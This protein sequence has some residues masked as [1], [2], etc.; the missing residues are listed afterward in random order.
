MTIRLQLVT[1]AEGVKKRTTLSVTSSYAT[2]AEALEAL[3]PLP[4]GW[5]E[6]VLTPSYAV[7]AGP[8]DNHCRNEVITSQ[9]LTLI[10]IL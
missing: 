7:Y 8:G 5:H 6:L 2:A 1:G 10:T 4:P 3:V 9:E